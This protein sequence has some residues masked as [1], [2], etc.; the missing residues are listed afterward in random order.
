MMMILSEIIL[1]NSKELNIP[2]VSLKIVNNFDMTQIN[3]GN[4]VIREYYNK[5][6]NVYSYI[7]ETMIVTK[8]IKNNNLTVYLNSIATIENSSEGGSENQV[9]KVN[10]YELVL[11]YINGKW[12]NTNDIVDSNGHILSGNSKRR[13]YIQADMDTSKCEHLIA[14]NPDGII[15][16]QEISDNTLVEKDGK[17]V[18]PPVVV[19]VM[20][21]PEWC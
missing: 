15:K 17:I 20:D 11:F 3:V 18:T 16:R 5:E 14:I 19:P 9:A 1:N 13:E 21:I 6:K 10:P 4:L 12:F 2:L 8:V 7:K